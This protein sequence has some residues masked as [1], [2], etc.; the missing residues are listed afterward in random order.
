MIFL[1][2]NLL[3]NKDWITAVFVL[4]FILL[5]IAKLM[6]N[7]RLFKLLTFFVNNDYFLKYKNETRLV[8]GFSIILF[9]V[10][11]LIISLLFYGYFVFY[12]PETIKNKGFVVF[13]DFFLIIILFLFL[14]GL[15]GKLLGILFQLEKPQQKIAFSKSGYLYSLSLLLLPFLLATFY[16]K[17]YNFFM[18]KLTTI[19]F[20]IL[21]V[22][23][24]VVVFKFNKK[25]IFYQLFYF[26]L[27]LCALEIAPVLLVYKIIA[28]F[29]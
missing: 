11:V 27:Y 25:N 7:D 6:Y 15:V 29:Y 17:A 1:T 22:F 9:V 26:M 3:D 4:I 10:L 21:L 28:V 19:V 13:L 12:Y 2:P 14:R 23:R 5:G 18:F 20:I 16:V 8:N 24:Y